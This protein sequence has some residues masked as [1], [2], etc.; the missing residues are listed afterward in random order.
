MHKVTI[1]Q[2]AVLEMLRRH[3]NDELS[4]IDIGIANGQERTKAANW[5]YGALKPLIDCGYVDKNPLNRRYSIT[6]SGLDAI[7]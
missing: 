7:N 1:K 4:A 5:A 6:P 3:R 2:R